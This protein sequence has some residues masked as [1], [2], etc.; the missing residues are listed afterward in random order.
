MI[1]P[2]TM[3]WLLA[4][5]PR[6]WTVQQRVVVFEVEK[7]DQL[8]VDACEATLRGWLGR[9]PRFAWADRGLTVPP[10]LVE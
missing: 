3:E 9:I 6:G 5:N 1:H 4:M 10:Y 2:R 7:H 8:L